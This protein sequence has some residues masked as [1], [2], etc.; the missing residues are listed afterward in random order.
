MRPTLPRASGLVQ[1]LNR[2]ALPC[3]G[4]QGTNAV[5]VKPPRSGEQGGG[6]T[7]L[8]GAVELPDLP[9]SEAPLEL[10]PDLGPQPVADSDTDLGEGAAESQRCVVATG[11]AVGRPRTLFFASSG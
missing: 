7:H 9:H 1:W 4:Q 10:T 5:C 6:A 11:T 2:A 8:C 3:H